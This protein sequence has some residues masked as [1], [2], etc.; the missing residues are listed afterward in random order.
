MKYARK[1]FEVPVSFITDETKTLVVEIKIFGEDED[2]MIDEV[3]NI[4]E[5]YIDEDGI[6]SEISELYNKL[7]KGIDKFFTFKAR[8]KGVLAGNNIHIQLINA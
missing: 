3:F 2:K 4:I 8:K 7:F 6:N 1:E 5:N